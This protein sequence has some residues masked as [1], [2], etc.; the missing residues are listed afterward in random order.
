MSKIE[1]LTLTLVAAVLVSG[2]AGI[3]EMHATHMAHMAGMMGMSSHTEATHAQM[4]QQIAGA[5][6]RADHEA[7]AQLFDQDAKAA[8]DKAAEYRHLTKT[9]TSG[10]DD[11]RLRV[12]PPLDPTG[13]TRTL[14][15]LY[16]QVAARN[17]A[18]AGVH[19][20]LATEAKD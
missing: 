20:Q 8:E 19:H 1:A 7:L 12:S 2:C 18:V 13:D 3:Q 5:R 9:Y 17:R 4:E 15:D 14:A 16:D 10:A 11:G 6:T